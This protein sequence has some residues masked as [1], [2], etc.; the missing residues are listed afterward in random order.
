[1]LNWLLQVVHKHHK[2]GRKSFIPGTPNLGLLWNGWVLIP[3]LAS[4]LQFCSHVPALGAA[5]WRQAQEYNF[6]TCGFFYTEWFIDS[7]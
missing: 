1:M 6:I 5:E 2:L 7:L 4:N 3:Y